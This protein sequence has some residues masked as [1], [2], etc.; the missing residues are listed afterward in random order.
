MATKAKEKAESRPS[1][2]PKVRVAK[3]HKKIGFGLRWRRDNTE[4]NQL[5]THLKMQ[6][7]NENLRRALALDIA[8]R[9]QGAHNENRERNLLC[10]GVTLKPTH[11]RQQT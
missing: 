4:S 11:R 3:Q 8:G 2:K 6:E 1:T 9:K 5:P 10:K 7:G